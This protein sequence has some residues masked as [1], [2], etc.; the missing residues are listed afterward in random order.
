MRK[1]DTLIVDGRAFS[2][3]RLC[4]L[5]H[6]QLAAWKDAQAS[7]GA[8]FELKIDRRP[9]AARCAAGRYREPSLLD[10]LQGG[11]S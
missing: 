1:P 4:A 8:L 6:A 7:D 10:M 5:R 11:A 3:R 2:W 9:P